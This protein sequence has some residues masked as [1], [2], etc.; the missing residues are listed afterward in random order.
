MKKQTNKKMKKKRNGRRK[1]LD[2][3]KNGRMKDEE[4]EG[5]REEDSKITKKKA[6]KQKKTKE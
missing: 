2:E 4:K 1:M 6:N 5:L 3:V